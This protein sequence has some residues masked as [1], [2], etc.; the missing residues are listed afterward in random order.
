M[1]GLPGT[2]PVL[3]F[4]SEPRAALIIA[5]ASYED[6][7]LRKLRAPASDA[8]D[9]AKVLGDPSIGGFLV[10]RV[11]EA[12]ER[13]TRRAID[14]FLSGR[15]IGELVV[16]YLSCHGVLD[17]RNRLYFA[18][19]DTVKAQLRSTGIASRWVLEQVE[20]CR[21]RRKVLILD[22]CFSGAFAHGSKADTD[23]DLRR[24]LAGNGRGQAVLTASR[25]SEYSFEGE[26]LPGMLS[27]GSVFSAGLVEGLRTGAADANGDGY[28]TVDEAY[29]YAYDYVLRHGASQTPQRWLSG[30]EGAIRLALSPAG[31]RQD[32]ESVLDIRSRA[33]WLLTDIERTA[34]SMTLDHLNGGLLAEVAK[35][36][37]VADINHA[38]HVAQSIR[39]LYWR[40]KALVGVAEAVVATEPERAAGLLADAEETAQLITSEN[41]QVALT[42]VAEALVAI[43][44]DHAEQTAQSINYG[45]WQA[46][47]L[48]QVAKALSVTRPEQAERIANSINEQRWKAEALT[49]VAKALAATNPERAQRTANSITAEHARVLALIEVATAL[50]A[51]D[52]ERATQILTDAERAAQSITQEYTR[53]SALIEVATALGA[54]DPERATQILTDA[55]RTAT[56]IADE[57]S[58][59]SQLARVVEALAAM[60]PEHAERTARSITREGV[61]VWALIKVAQAL[62][63]SDPV[64]AARLFSDAE[65]T[66]DWITAE[67]TKMGA[68]IETAEALAVID[69]DHA[70]EV[71]THAGDTAGSITNEIV[72]AWALTRIALALT[73]V[74]ADRAVQLFADAEAAA[75]SIP[76]EVR[77]DLALAELA[78]VLAATEP[79]HAELV[80]QS[81]LEQYL[82]VKTLTEVA[83][84]LVSTDP[85]RA[86]RLLTDAER[87][88]MSVTT[89]KADAL[90]H[91]ARA[92]VNLL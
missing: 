39:S 52:P 42:E 9:I 70:V 82:R 21:A 59:D 35:A 75:R 49:Q 76:D 34:R 26:A 17:D 3:D 66:A 54:T 65:R 45:D 1:T 44:P 2:R 24:R 11:C 69:P 51:T 6:P 91:V 67:G 15:G 27:A 60:H 63:A 43:D 89:F 88:A 5:T 83:K 41:G 85:A 37:A 64:W 87:I 68:L 38:E 84:V 8:E 36:L 28:I 86:A 47:V 48:A 31:V 30:G 79:D 77:R 90:A 56:S 46:K 57:G 25:A 19:T 33:T 10:T 74:D 92:V 20:E 12:D 14:T 7:S 16:I 53:V 55:E 78:N 71:L 40:T 13:Q 29:E 50:A 73:V 4:T 72:K 23:L 81:I 18:A 61:R 32:A 58:R 80:G 22:C 62:A